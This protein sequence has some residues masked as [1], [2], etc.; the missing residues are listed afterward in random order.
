[1]FGRKQLADALFDDTGLM[2]C[3]TKKGVVRCDAGLVVLP[4]RGG[5]TPFGPT[6][7]QTGPFAKSYNSARQT[8]CEGYA[9]YDRR[10]DRHNIL[11][12]QMMMYAR[13]EGRWN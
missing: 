1:V 6:W 11:P 4:N 5:D 10:D 8:G 13:L 12:I 2:I 9:P 7:N 3:G